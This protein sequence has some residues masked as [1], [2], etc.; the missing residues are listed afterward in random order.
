MRPNTY[1]EEMLCFVVMMYQ[2]HLVNLGVLLGTFF[3]FLLLTCS[4]VN[5]YG[6]FINFLNYCTDSSYKKF[7]IVYVVKV[8]L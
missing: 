5:W 4:V 8:L 2:K 1:L 3:A 6:Q 7:A